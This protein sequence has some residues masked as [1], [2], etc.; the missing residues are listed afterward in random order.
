MPTIYTRLSRRDEIERFIRSLPAVLAGKAPDI[1]GVAHGFAMRVAFAFFSIIR[2]NF[3]IKSRGG[4][5]EAGITWPRLSERYLAYTR[6]M[7]RNG[8]GSRQPPHAGGLAPGEH[9]GF[10]TRQQLAS[11]RKVYGGVLS[12][13]SLK[14]PLGEAKARAA[15]IAWAASKRA[16]VRTKLE[17]FGHRD[18]E[19]LRDRGILFNSLSPGV[20][21][22]AD[23]DATYL[24][25]TPEQIARLL[26]DGILCGTNVEYA[27]KHHLGI[28]VPARPFW[29]VDGNLPE[30]WIVEIAEV[31]ASGLDQI[32]RL[33]A[34]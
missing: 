4:T 21:T 11:W 18:V 8:S 33:F 17:V 20:L 29:P 24:P 19:T 2:E 5:D 1:H 7:G 12:R 15:S 34:A 13:L 25:A 22:V 23:V 16:G 28:G 30:A 6:P 32:G 3:I 14:I 10:M 9:D 31:G 27:A 26:P